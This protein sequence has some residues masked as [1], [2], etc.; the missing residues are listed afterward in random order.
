MKFKKIF[1]TAILVL[2]FVTIIVACGNNDNNMADTKNP[3]TTL[4]NQEQYEEEKAPD[5][6]LESQKQPNKVEEEALQQEE[7]DKEAILAETYTI[8]LN[9]CTSDIVGDYLID[10]VF[11]SWISSNFGEEIIFKLA[12]L[13]ETGEMSNNQWHHLTGN[14]I[15]VLWNMYCEDSGLQ[16][17]TLEQIYKKECASEEKIVLDFIGD[18]NFDENWSTMEHLDQ[19]PGGIYDCLSPNLLKELQSADIMMVN[20]EFTYSTGGTPVP[21]KHYTF[22]AN[23]QRVTLLDD[24][25]ADIV[26]L[27]NNHAYDYGEEALIDTMET[28]EA[29]DMPYVGAG[30]NLQEAMEPIYFIANG[31][32]IA[33]VSA[34]QIERSYN[35]TKEATEDKAGVLK[36][37]NPDKFVT[38]IEKAN[39]RADYVIVYVHWG[40]EQNAYFESDQ[41]ALADAFIQAGADAIIGAHTHCLQGCEYRQGVP[42]IYSLGNFWFN[43]R[44]LDSGISQIIIQRDGTMDFRFI[45]TIQV[46]NEAYLVE[47]EGEKQRILDYMEGISSGVTIDENGYI[48]SEQ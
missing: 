24:M 13:V 6:N 9:A 17:D 43:V 23:P 44:K 16:T 46:G 12:E 41:T 15:H 31:R 38:V 8:I 45:P 33:I 1:F 36:T 35:F 29:A 25:G 47:E 37:L 5:E 48:L 40:T 7:I 21:G 42:I 3:E 20:N 2:L 4:E 39:A 28:L 34:T 19:Q 32:K 11:L 26:S 18:I 14:S 27:A 10:E 30:R 22:R